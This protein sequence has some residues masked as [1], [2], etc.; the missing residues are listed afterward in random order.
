MEE[1]DVTEKGEEITVLEDINLEITV[2][3]FEPIIDATKDIMEQASDVVRSIS[4]NK[5]S[6]N[7]KFIDKVAELF[8]QGVINQEQANKLRTESLLAEQYHHKWKDVLRLAHISE[9]QGLGLMKSAVVLMIVPYCLMRLIGF[10]FMVISQTFEFF[11]TL[12]NSVFGETKEVQIDDS[13][14]KVRHKTGY[15]IFAKVLLGFIISIVLLAMTFL[16]IKVFTG[17]DIFLWLRAVTK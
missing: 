9:P 17:F 16:T 8:S 1:F 6:K 13:G 7:E 15:N 14:N 10:F 12:F 2:P 4:A 3:K 5:A 11:N